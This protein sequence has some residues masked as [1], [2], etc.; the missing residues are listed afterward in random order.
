M[1][2]KELSNV[3]KSGIFDKR[4]SRNDQSVC[5]H[6]IIFSVTSKWNISNSGQG[7]PF[8]GK[9]IALKRGQF[10]KCYSIYWQDIYEAFSDNCSI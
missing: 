5:I 2:I 9:L 6:D 4:I 8:I 10:I 3:D 1:K 7:I